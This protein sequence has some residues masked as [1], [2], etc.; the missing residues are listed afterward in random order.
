MSF[1][2]ELQRIKEEIIKYLPPEIKVKKIEFEGP[3]IAVY[4]ENTN[5]ESIESSEILKDLAKSMRKRVVFRWNVEKR[6]DP[7]ET[8]DYI[9]NL[10]SEDAEISEIEFDHTRGEVIIESGKPGLVIG[11][12]GVNLKEIRMNTFWQPKTIRTPPLASRTISLIR[13]MLTKE[14]QNQKDILLNI[15][16]RIH[17]PTLFNN[18][19]IR[20]TSLGGFREVG[21][22][23]ILM[24]TR[25][26]NIL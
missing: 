24:Q 6:K 5:L 9:R 1:E 4:S 8:E 10:I 17:R 19:D 15:G 14:R 3:E 23:C 2:G 13:Q 21:R 26:S 25:D 11:K 18:L 12:K 20:L 7:S 16:K 22:S